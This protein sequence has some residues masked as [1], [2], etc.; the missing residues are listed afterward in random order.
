MQNLPNVYLLI[1][2]SATPVTASNGS[3]GE[4]FD[5]GFEI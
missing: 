1:E 5:A 3:F 2:E 4:G